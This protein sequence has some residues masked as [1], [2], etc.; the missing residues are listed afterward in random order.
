MQ[1]M[2]YDT[3]DHGI[4]NDLQCIEHNYKGESHEYSNSLCGTNQNYV[5]VVE[6]D[7][8][9]PVLCNFCYPDDIGDWSNIKPGFG[10]GHV[11][12]PE[13][14]DFEELYKTMVSKH[15]IS[16]NNDQY[17]KAKLEIIN[18]QTRMCKIITC[19]GTSHYITVP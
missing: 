17:D 2:A 6:L 13:S 19:E 7:S 5:L 1:A 18:L 14:T 10:Q 12:M 8:E 3:M 4:I 11:F 15:N 16:A 9:R